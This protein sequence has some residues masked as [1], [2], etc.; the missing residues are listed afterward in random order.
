[1][2]AKKL[3]IEE[4]DGSARAEARHRMEAELTF[5]VRGVDIGN[6]SASLV[7]PSPAK[8]ADPA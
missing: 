2:T 7:P 3:Q 5:K 6:A 8:P 1:M 4:D